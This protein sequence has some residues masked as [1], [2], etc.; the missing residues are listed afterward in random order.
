MDKVFALKEHASKMIDPD[1][2]ITQRQ[3][4]VRNGGE[5]NEGEEQGSVRP[6]DSGACRG[7]GQGN[8]FCTPMPEYGMLAEVSSTLLSEPVWV[9]VPRMCTSCDQYLFSVCGFGIA[10]RQATQL[11]LPS[12]K[13]KQNQRLENNV[14]F[15][16]RK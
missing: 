14:I 2:V 9:R 4:M 3:C 8:P 1:K 12:D 6:C 7:W 11:A 16:R 15:Y 5:L 13:V 10:H